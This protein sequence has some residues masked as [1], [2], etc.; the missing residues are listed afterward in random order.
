MPNIMSDLYDNFVTTLTIHKRMNILMPQML[1][2]RT[3]F[4]I[5]TMPCSYSYELMAYFY[6]AC[7]FDC[8]SGA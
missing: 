4:N 1:H 7:K 8:I 5:F 6:S 3:H 2:K